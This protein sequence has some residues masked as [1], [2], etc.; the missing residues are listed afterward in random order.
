M[1]ELILSVVGGAVAAIAIERMYN[2][3]RADAADY[4]LWLDLNELTLMAEESDRF[5][6]GMEYVV[7]GRRVEKP[8]VVDVDIWNGGTKDIR[9][10]MFNGM[11][12]IE[13]KLNV[14]VIKELNGGREFA[15]EATAISLDSDG[16]VRIS[17]SLIRNGMIKRYRLLVDGKPH[18]TWDSQVADLHVHD[19]NQEWETPTLDRRIARIAAR[20][21]TALLVVFFCALMVSALVIPVEVR[22]D[23]ADALPASLAVLAFVPG[24]LFMICASLYAYGANASRRPRQASKARGRALSQAPKTSSESL[25]RT[26]DLR[27]RD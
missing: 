21:L 13:V 10:D 2:G 5:E 15:A 23:I 16:V 7:D 8:F 19:L 9:A 20:V 3:W 27:D 1:I 18:L 17:P 11:S 26:I 4:E 22:R 14:P 25:A 12:P 6:T 24:A